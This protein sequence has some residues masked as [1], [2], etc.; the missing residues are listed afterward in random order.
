MAPITGGKG[1][2]KVALKGGEEK[3][4]YTVLLYD[5]IEGEREKGGGRG[6]KNVA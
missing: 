3:M 5:L 1:D 4:P 2:A 6:M